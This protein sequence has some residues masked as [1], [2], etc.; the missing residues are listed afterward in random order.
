MAKEYGRSKNLRSTYKRWFTAFLFI[1]F[2]ALLNWQLYGDDGE[3]SAD[4]TGI[5]RFLF[6]SL[7]FGLTGYVLGPKI[8]SW[9]SGFS[10][11]SKRDKR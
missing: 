1:G 11:K 5:Y 9:A 10:M 4:N 2:Y 3:G 8:F 7:V 6:G